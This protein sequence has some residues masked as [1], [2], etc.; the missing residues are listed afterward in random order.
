M[1]SPGSW[2]FDGCYSTHQTLC[3]A[4]CQKQASG[5]SH[6]RIDFVCEQY[7][8]HGMVPT[9]MIITFHEVSA[10]QCKVQTE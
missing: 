7:S 10:P 4:E 3:C 9:M 1:P 8:V 2:R 5:A 6:A